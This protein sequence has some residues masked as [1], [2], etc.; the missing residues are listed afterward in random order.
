MNKPKMTEA[1]SAVFRMEKLLE[2]LWK[3]IIIQYKI[4]NRDV[5]VRFERIAR[6]G[7]KHLRNM[8][9]YIESYPDATKREILAYL[10]DLGEGSPS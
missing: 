10:K 6:A 7:E 8:N 3:Q 5:A 2:R 4:G 1:E 9:V